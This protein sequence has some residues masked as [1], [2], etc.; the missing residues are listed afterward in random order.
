MI[1]SSPLG[2]GM[3]NTGFLVLRSTLLDVLPKK[4]LAIMPLPWAPIT[5]T[6][7]ANSSAFLRITSGGKPSQTSIVFLLFSSY[8]LIHQYKVAKLIPDNSTLSYLS[9]LQHLALTGWYSIIIEYL[10]WSKMPKIKET[11]HSISFYKIALSSPRRWR[12]H[13]SRRP[14]FQHSS[15]PTFQSYMSFW[16]F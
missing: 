14:L 10:K 16:I 13:T 7:Q 12:Y 11:L 8:F 2:N 4:V 6:S 5:I 9:L 1:S 15:I 3:I